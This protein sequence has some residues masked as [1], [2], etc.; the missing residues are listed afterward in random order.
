[1]TNEEV[2]AFIAETNASIEDNTK[3]SDMVN[4]INLKLTG[5]LYRQIFERL[6]STQAP[7]ADFIGFA[8]VVTGRG[9]LISENA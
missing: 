7:D 5:E 4:Q 2:Y 8:K 9:R 3:K 6:L 1:M